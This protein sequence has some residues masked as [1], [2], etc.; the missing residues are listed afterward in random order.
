M[1]VPF[2]D[3]AGLYA[4]RSEKFGAIMHETAKRGGFILQRDVDEFEE[5]LSAF[6]GVKYAVALSDCT[7]AM[8]LG[9][10]AMALKQGDEVI[11]PSH[12][13]L[14]AAQSIHFAGGVP[15]PVEL[16][17]DFLVDPAAVAAAVTPR[18]R[19]IMPVHV[20]GRICD[21]DPIMEIAARHKLDVIEDSAQA[22]GATYKGRSAGGIGL[23]GAYSFYPSKTLGCF[24]DA[25]ALV[26]NDPSIAEAVRSMRNHGANRQKTIEPGVD[27][28]GTNARMDNIHAAIL[29]YKLGYYREVIERRREIAAK[30][31]FAMSEIEGVEL[32]PAPDAS[33]DYFDIFQN[34]ELCVPRRDELRKFLADREIG[35]IVQWGGIALHQLKNLGFTQSLPKTE[36]FFQRSLLLPLNHI[37]SDAQVDHVISSV[38]EFFERKIDG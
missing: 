5:N 12:S 27:L 32:P 28:W 1:R 23:W 15:V 22:V 26:T 7:N 34:F 13:F 35:T 19:A 33:S 8:L 20:N 21:M 36:R 18:T 31:H 25:G 9:L 30:Y 11:I 2:F 4:E 10:R 37:L 24:G 29:V 6:T 3:W 16:T 38:L 14:A 17:Y